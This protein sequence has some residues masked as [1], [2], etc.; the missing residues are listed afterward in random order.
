MDKVIATGS[1]KKGRLILSFVLLFSSPILAVAA[2]G[3]SSVTTTVS[4]TV[5]E[6]VSGCND[7]AALFSLGGISSSSSPGTPNSSWKSGELPLNVS[8]GYSCSDDSAISFQ[9]FSIGAG[10][11]ASNNLFDTS[12]MSTAIYCDQNFIGE[13]LAG[14]TAGVICSGSTSQIALETY[15]P[16]NA[17][18]GTELS[19]TV[20]VTGVI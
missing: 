15:V 2:H 3:D 6:D 12:A 13:G 11:W 18:P 20:E 17:T 1:M 8:A 5:V 16:A 9:G 10:I 7:A 14:G 4:F 19:N